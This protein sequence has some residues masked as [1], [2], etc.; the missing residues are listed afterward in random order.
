MSLSEYEEK[1]TSKRR[2]KLGDDIDIRS[3]KEDLSN[4]DLDAIV[5]EIIFNEKKIKTPK[6]KKKNLKAKL[7]D[8]ETNKRNKLK[9]K[10]TTST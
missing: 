9:N 8:I 2:S 1:K 10:E 5:D 3:M 6:P 4:S 7:K